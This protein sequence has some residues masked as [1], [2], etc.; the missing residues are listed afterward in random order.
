MPQ[1]C[2]KHGVLKSESESQ[3]ND[4]PV[5]MFA[6]WFKLVNRRFRQLKLETWFNIQSWKSKSNESKISTMKKEN[7]ISFQGKESEMLNWYF[8]EITQLLSQFTTSWS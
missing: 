4:M 7:E 6:T 3:D 2:R 8:S 1:N 5:Q